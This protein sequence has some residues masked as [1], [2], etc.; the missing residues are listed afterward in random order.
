M[1]CVYRGRSPSPVSDP[2]SPDET[3]RPERLHLR[4]LA[5]RH[6]RWSSPAL[7]QRESTSRRRLHVHQTAGQSQLATLYD[8][9]VTRAYSPTVLRW[10]II[11]RFVGERYRRTG[12]VASRCLGGD[13]SLRACVS[14]DPPTWAYVQRSSSMD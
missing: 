12:F 1:R 10:L 6:P 7:L 9:Y 4:S 8:P 5:S 11:G 13:Y 14:K 3:Q 2:E